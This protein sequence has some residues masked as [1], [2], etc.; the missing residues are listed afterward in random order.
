MHNVI[1]QTVPHTDNSI[2]KK[3]FARVIS[4]TFFVILNHC[5]WLL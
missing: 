2:N 4:C 1:R 5:L 3:E